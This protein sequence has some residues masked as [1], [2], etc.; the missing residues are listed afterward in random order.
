MSLRFYNTP[1]RSIENF[2]PREPDTTKLYTC[3]PTV[4]DTPHVGNWAA[5]I[6]WDILV[7][8]LRINGY[9]VTRIMNI[10]DVGH[11]VSDEDTGEYKVEKGAR[12]EGKTAWDV[13]QYYTDDFLRG[14]AALNCIMPDHLARATDFIPQ[15]LEL[16]RTLKQKGYTY[17]IS[18]GIYF[19]TAKFPRYADFAHLDLKDQKAGARVTFNPEKR[20]HSD[21]A[22]WKFTAPRETRDMQWQTPVDLLEDTPLNDTGMGF[23]G[24]HL[25]CSAI[26]MTLLGD[27]LDIHTGGIDHIPVHHTNEIAQ[28]EAAT[29]LPFSSFWLHANFMTVDG[30]KISKSLNNG[31]T[32]EDLA[33]KGFTPLD[34]RML[35]LQSHYRTEANFTFDSMESAHARLKHWREAASLR[36]QTRA[37]A[38]EASLPSLATIRVLLETL[39]DDID[40]PGALQV[41]DK[42]ITDVERASLDTISSN[43]LNDLF[44]AIDG[45]LG[46]NLLAATPDIEDEDKAL[47]LARVQARVSKDYRRSDDIRDELLIKGI[48]LRDVP[49]DT[50]WF[51]A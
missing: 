42:I 47:I 51:W 8:L 11:L 2:V 49:G 46:L 7:R 21:F 9:T 22:L 35:I 18:D 36:W 43:S 34:L 44:E 28:S 31:Y 41:I 37:Y 14:L 39:N 24:W 50:V 27:T 1:T 29:D 6:R 33:E 13:A 20:N 30:M 15:Q 5:Y 38:S 17:Q 3:G 40:T 32:L 23:P 26:A 48:G 12:R 19:D 4:Y 16:V 10:T 25:E 45:L